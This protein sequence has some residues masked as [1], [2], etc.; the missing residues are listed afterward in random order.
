MTSKRTKVASVDSVVPDLH[1]KVP[2]V[3][4]LVPEQF[5]VVADELAGLRVG[6]EDGAA[7]TRT[8]HC[9]A[10]KFNTDASRSCSGVVVRLV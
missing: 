6:A 4:A 1:L 8:C 5:L 2:A 3:V 10:S 7:E 9:R